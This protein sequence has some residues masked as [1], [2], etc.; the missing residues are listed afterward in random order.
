MTRNIRFGGASFSLIVIVFLAALG[1][2][3]FGFHIAELNAP[4]DALTCKSKKPISSSLAAQLSRWFSSS[5]ASSSSSSS[6]FP[7]CIPMTEAAFAS[8]SSIFT[9][10]GLAGALAAG[11]VTT[12][13]GRRP[14]MRMTSAFFLLGALLETVAGGVPLLFLGRLVAGVGAGAATVIVPLYVSEVAPPAARGLFG[15]ST[16]VMINMG[17]LLTQIEG[18]FLSHGAA[19]RWILASGVGLAALH[20]VGLHVVPESPAWLASKGRFGAARKELRRIRGSRADVADETA[21]WGD[22]DVTSGGSS[23]E[24]QGLL[25]PGPG[26][27]APADKP[28]LGFLEVLGDPDALQGIVAC[29]GIATG[30]QLCGIN[31]IIMYSVSLLNDLLPVSS[32][33]LTILISLVNLGT[34]LACAPLPDRLGRRRCLLLSIAGQGSSSLLLAFSIQAG[35]KALSALAVLSFVAWFAVG[36]GPVPFIMASE[37]VGPDAVGAAQSWTLGANYVATFVIAQ[38]FPVANSWLN[39]LLGGAGWIYYVFGAAAAAVWG[40]VYLQ[41]P[42]TRGK[43]NADEVWGRERRLD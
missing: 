16:Q 11:P 26:M 25:S 34:T 14:A 2:L 30:Q 31:S 33:L 13:T 15:T 22:F 12:L 17:I 10:G 39:G 18:Y 20:V 6:L 4:Q 42:E 9:L 43:R 24:E 1:P 29:V 35:F 37:L 38:F 36:L 8:I 19:W 7:S 21:G 27:L 5:S 3:Q 40:F 32:A 28:A 41:V 23:A